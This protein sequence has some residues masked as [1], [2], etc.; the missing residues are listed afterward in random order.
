MRL[1][2]LLIISALLIISSCTESTQSDS[3]SF[4]DAGSDMA[5]FDIQG[6]RGCRGLLPENS[7]PG[8]LKAVQLGVTTLELDVVV[9]RDSMVIVSH[10]PWL[11]S[12]ICMDPTGKPV[13]DHSE[14]SWNLFQMT[15]A[16]IR[17]CDCGS[18]V[19]PRFPEQQ[20][21]SVYK[22]LLSEVIETVEVYVDANRRSAIRY[23]IEIKSDPRGDHLFHPEP[24][25]FARL[26]LDVIRDKEIAERVTIQSFDMRPLIVLN[27]QAPD[28][29]LAMLAGGE[30]NKDS[31]MTELGFIP[32]AY[33][34]NFSLV[35]Q[36]LRS[37]TSELGM[38]LIPWTVNDTAD[39]HRMIDI[40]V[41]GIITDYPDRLIQLM[42]SY[43]LK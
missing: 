15:A 43:S 2:G 4:E 34:P 3:Q 5:W 24:E 25:A 13:E 41:D 17:N 33:S 32:T 12:V 36:N 26:V 9:S 27:N 29:D 21:M 39:M 18:R 22:P 14:K 23:N 11:S 40:G 28:I 19:H 31:L 8:F 37:W 38:A 35:N 42:D 10:E 6:H 1:H 20:P 7:I 16:E 30:S